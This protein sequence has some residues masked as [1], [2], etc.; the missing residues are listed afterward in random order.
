MK[1]VEEEKK[2]LKENFSK[3]QEVQK[4]KEEEVKTLQEELQNSRQ[5]AMASMKE[6]ENLKQEVVK[7]K[8]EVEM[9]KNQQS[10]NEKFKEKIQDFERLEAELTLLRITLMKNLLNQTLRTSQR[11]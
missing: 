7:F 6:A 10:I 5:Q 9:L 11:L 4:S 3:Y 8:R 1:K 2:N